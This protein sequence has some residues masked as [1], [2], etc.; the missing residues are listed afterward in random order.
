MRYFFIFHKICNY[1]K[2]FETISHGE[3]E[4]FCEA[5]SRF[6]QKCSS[7]EIILTFDDGFKSDVD[8]YKTAKTYGLQT[9]HFVVPNYV[10]KL[11]YMTVQDILNLVKIGAV[12]GSH[13]Y[14]HS[15]LNLL[16]AADLENDLQ[17]S[18]A[19]ILKNL[20]YKT[21]YISVPYG[22]ARKSVIKQIS[23]YYEFIFYIWI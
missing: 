9:L 13:S 20:G 7:S 11:D 2:D 12:I 6:N 17:L 18:Q 1:D 16:S 14:S 3:F 5:A 23:K 15:N 10:G 8:A 19:W 4:R 22:K 21:P